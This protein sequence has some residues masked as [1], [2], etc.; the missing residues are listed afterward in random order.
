MLTVCTCLHTETQADAESRGTWLKSSNVLNEGFYQSRGFVT[1]ANITLGLN[2]PMW[3]KPPV[4]VK[5]VGRIIF[6]AFVE[7]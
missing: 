3:D 1:A 5:V 7:G 2:N 6:I 4:V